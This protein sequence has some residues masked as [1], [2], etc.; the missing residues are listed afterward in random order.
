LEAHIV[1]RARSKAPA[2]VGINK[3][4]NK[5][6]TPIT[7]SNSISVKACLRQREDAFF[8]LSPIYLRQNTLFPGLGKPKLVYFEVGFVA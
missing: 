2:I 3:P 7:T 5:A 6:M 1:S 4:I 8:I